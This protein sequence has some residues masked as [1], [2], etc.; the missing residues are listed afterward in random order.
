M[1][2]Y[3]KG[4]TVLITGASSGIGAQLAIDIASMGGNLVL[5]ART[6]AKLESVKK[7]VLEL[8]SSIKVELIEMSITEKKLVKNEMEKLL[9]NTSV[10]ML[11]NNAGLALGNEKIDTA[12]TDDW[13]QMIDTNLKGLLYV[14]RALIPHFKTLGTS[15]IIN[16][17]SVAG[18][19]AYPGGNVYC[20]TKA[21][22][23]SLG[24]AMNADLLGTGVK[25]STIA[26]GAVETN[27]S[28]VRFP[29]ELE[30][31][32][33]VYSGYTPLS[34]NDISEAIIGIIN[35]APHVN[36]QYMDIMPT[37][38]RNPFLISKLDSDI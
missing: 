12:N 18:K 22:V 36:I 15:H 23:H 25:V 4:K 35:T 26:P 29:G 34:A 24:E 13:D 20:A 2:N 10:D 30:K 16:I 17:G 9:K 32:K 33:L 27:F 5:V 19:T 3:I 37:A 21:A 8:N 14:S 31:Q 28:A 1:N 11:V 6:L 7:Q 38:Q